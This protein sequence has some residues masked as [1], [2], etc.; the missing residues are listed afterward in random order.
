V[1][2]VNIGTR[3]HRRERGANVVDVSYNQ[4]AIYNAIQDQIKIKK[5]PKSLVYGDGEAGVKIASLLEQLPLK[6]HKTIVY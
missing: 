2:V 1:P 5:A 6:F 3:Q 4:D